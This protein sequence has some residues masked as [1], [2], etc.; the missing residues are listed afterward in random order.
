M[1]YIFNIL[2]NKLDI[3]NIPVNL[4][5]EHNDFENI[6]LTEINSHP[7]RLNIKGSSN[8]SNKKLDGQ[9]DFMII[10]KGLL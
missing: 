6:F 8:Y 10:N 4:K 7:L 1:L 9:F 5:V 2:L 3:F